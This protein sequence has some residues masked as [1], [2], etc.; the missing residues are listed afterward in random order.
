[1]IDFVTVVFADELQSLKHQ[2]RS[3]DLYATDVGTIHVAVNEDSD[4]AKKINRSWW[5]QWHNRVKIVPRHQFGTQ[6]SENGWVS[7]QALKLLVS[8]QASSAWSIVLDAKT[9]FVRPVPRVQSRPRVGQLNIYPVFEPSRQI[10]NHLFGID[11]QA[12]LGPG[13][14]PFV[15]NTDQVQQMIAWIEQRVGQ[16]FAEWFQ[17][18]GRLTEFLLYTGWILYRT[19]SL[20]HL[21]DVKHIDMIPCNLCHSETN[22]FD[23]KFA[24]MQRSTTVSVHRRAWPKLTADQQT[25]YLNFLNNRGIA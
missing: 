2:A 18:Q 5:G 10:V 15:V 8:A 21:Y 11:L 23:R 4:L 17:A 12:Q 16:S 20:D 22:A 19:G 25:Q 14:V 7:Q 1:M 9:F 24:D 13:G 3:L 6:W